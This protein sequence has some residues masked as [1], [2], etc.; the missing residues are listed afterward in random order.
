MTIVS[1]RFVRRRRERRRCCC[2]IRARVRRGSG[3]PGR[4]SLRP[5]F[6]CTPWTSTATATARPARDQPTHVGR[7]RGARRCRCSRTA[8]GAHVVGHSYG[9]AV[10]LK[11]ATMHPAAVRSVVAYEPVLFR[12]LLDDG[13]RA[14]SLPPASIA[15]AT[16]IRDRR[17]GATSA[18]AAQRFVDFWCGSGAWRLDAHRPGRP[19]L[20]RTHAGRL[21][22]FDALFRERPRT[23]ALAR[24]AHA[25]AVPD[26]RAHGHGHAS[27]RGAAASR[28]SDARDHAV[29]QAMGHMGPITHAADV[30]ANIAAFLDRQRATGVV[31]AYA[32]CA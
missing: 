2:C 5:G 11:L 10:A 8:G 4:R 24:L 9:A 27:H 12:W 30:N 13:P 15:L 31:R 3:T 28:A 18:S 21:R 7:R 25:D 16:A 23:P 14:T 26:R 32:R 22:H 29:L 1:P 19:S 20:A 17:C 6:A